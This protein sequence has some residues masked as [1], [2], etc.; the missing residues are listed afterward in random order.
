M[1]DFLKS[2]CSIASGVGSLPHTD[3]VQAVDD[4]LR[5]CPSMPYAPTLPNISP[6][7]AII[8]HDSE[9]LPG[10]VV[11]GNKLYVDRSL[12]FSLEME[13]VYLDFMEQ[14]VDRY[15]AS[16]GYAAGYFEMAN[17]DL[18]QV[19]CVKCQITGPVTFGLTISDQDRRPLAYDGQYFDMLTKMLALRARWYE[20]LMQKT[21][22]R[23]TL[24]VIDE[25]YLAALG[26]S[27]MQLTPEMIASVFEDIGSLIE[28]GIGVHCCSNT[29]WGLLMSFKPAVISL[30]AYGTAREFLLY[31]NQ[32][33]SYLESGGIIAWGIV[34][35]ELDK[36]NLET[37]ESLWQRYLS[38]RNELEPV[39]GKALFD[40]QAVITPSCGLR[41]ADVPG[42]IRI[43]ETVAEISKRARSL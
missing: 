34:P 11:Q 43:M 6:F 8:W 31:R 2:P 19:W 33:R 37:T 3:P 26:S 7:E 10:R 32:I 29:D 27:V 13:R 4:I 17:R 23:Q 28:G 41:L 25:P 12:D 40:I 16:P 24:V 30:D 1:A 20:V 14:N 22:A 35:A 42:A 18:S 36:F 21:G 9:F 5:L 15:A 39:V 38:I